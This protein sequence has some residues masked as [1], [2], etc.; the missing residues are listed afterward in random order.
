[1][2]LGADAVLSR[3][4]LVGSGARIGTSLVLGYGAEIDAATL[5]DR[6]VIGSQVQIGDATIGSDVVVARGAFIGDGAQIGSNV[7]IGPDVRIEAGAIVGSNVRL[8][9]NAVVEGTGE[10]QAG[11]RIGRD[12]R[13]KANAVVGPN[14]IVRADVVV[15]TWQE[16]TDY[17]PRGTT[18]DDLPPPI[19]DLVY[20]AGENGRRWRDGTVATSCD[21][22]LN[23]PEGYSYSGETG[24][25][26]YLIRPVPTISILGVYCDQ[27]RDGGGWMLAAKV[28]RWHEGSASANEPRGW[29]G[30]NALNLSLLLD[31]ISRDSA[32]N[33]LHTHG[34]QRLQKV[35][36]GGI[37]Q[38]RFVLIA[39]NNTAQRATWFKGITD[40]TFL[41]WFSA[42]SH[43]A[44]PVCTNE[45]MTANCRTG[46][47]R[48]VN[49]GVT[50]L[51]GMYLHEVNAAW[52]D[53][54]E[55]HM[56]LNEDGSPSYSGVC[57]YTFDDPDW[58]DSASSHWGN[59]LE[60]WLR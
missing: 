7:V 5:G 37:S 17:V 34:G 14:A 3:S 31:D 4:T 42:T 60:I 1:M 23:P 2:V 52:G 20:E 50:A 44:T 47:I 21:E 8:R 53:S 55:L 30:G 28:D 29:F 43:T 10:V 22:Y 35:W 19:N 16:V 26:R 49:G 27:E 59:G 32:G 45:A 9:K 58:A 12:S 18:L 46:D 11:A 25:G 51:D 15:G 41:Q 48:S 13:V 6:V 40:N 39:E 38:A 57:S 33:S 54:G 24:S 36:E 56:R